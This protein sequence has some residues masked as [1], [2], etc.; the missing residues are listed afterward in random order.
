MI[1]AML[2]PTDAFPLNPHGKLDRRAVGALP[3]PKRCTEDS[4]LLNETE[5]TLKDLW[6]EC[7]PKSI[8]DSTRIASRS[9]FF[10]LGGNSYQLVHL[11]RL[12]RRRFNV[13]VP[14]MSLYDSSSLSSMAGKINSGESVVTVDWKTETSI[15]KALLAKKFP[16][17]AHAVQ[18]APCTKTSGLIVILTGATGYMGS[19]V[20]KLLAEDDRV[21]LIHCVA[22]R[23]HTDNSP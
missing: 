5:I 22:L 10:R 11:Q 14:V 23:E 20:L 16:A 6:I 2:I 8:V 3:L 1:P 17:S 9:D 13:H 19:R 18:S 4:G 12:I 15:A 21:A 7:L